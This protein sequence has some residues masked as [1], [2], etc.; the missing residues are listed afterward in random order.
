MGILVPGRP[1]PR[2]DRVWVVAGSWEAEERQGAG[3]IPVDPA[4]RIRCGGDAR[5]RST[6]DGRGAG[7][8]QE[9]PHQEDRRAHHLRQRRP[10]RRHPRFTPEA[11]GASQAL[12]DLIGRI[13]AR[14]HATPAQV[15]LAWLL[16]RSPGSCR[17]P[18][19]VAWSAWTRTSQ[20]PPSNSPPT[21]S[22][23]LRT[24]PHRSPSRGPVSRTP[25]ANDRPLRGTASRMASLMLAS[26][27]DRK[28]RTVN[29]GEAGVLV[30]VQ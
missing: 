1:G 4:Q 22:V 2:R 11:R 25:R 6:A 30:R 5:S 19:P 17:S 14:K 15:A 29:Q 18:A 12:V 7:H 16:A 10:P 8:R 3:R 26:R 20:Q 9:L 24:P 23:R 28:L 27:L 13:A 21:I